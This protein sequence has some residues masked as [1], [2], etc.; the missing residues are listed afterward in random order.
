MGLKKSREKDLEVAEILLD[1]KETIF[2]KH[3]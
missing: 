3:S 1:W 2:G